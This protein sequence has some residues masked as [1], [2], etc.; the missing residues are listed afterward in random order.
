MQPINPYGWASFNKYRKGKY[1]YVRPG[2][3]I[4]LWNSDNSTLMHVTVVLLVKESQFWL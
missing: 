4:F 1:V 3:Y 2:T